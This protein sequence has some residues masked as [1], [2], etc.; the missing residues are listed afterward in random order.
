MIA[1]PDL[2]R[3][4]SAADP[5][6][7]VRLLF[8]FMR[9]HGASYYDESVTQLEHALQTAALAKAEDG[10]DTLVVAA[11]LH[12]IG[13]L[14]VDEHAGDGSFLN[15]DRSHESVAAAFLEPFFPQQAIQPILHHVPAK[16]YLCT[17]DPGY[18]AT[19]SPAS[20]RSLELQGGKLDDAER[21][22]L[23][24]NPYLDEIVALR[25]WDDRAKTSGLGVPVLDDYADTL[26][27]VLDYQLEKELD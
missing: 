25:R 2:H 9:E 11:L 8:A 7:F 12:D 14:L 19:L 13:H 5:D 6:G 15:Q 10:R 26:K 18:H 20:R 23:E 22:A 21:A 3:R 4:L 1:M 27:R 16:R 24:A 17:I